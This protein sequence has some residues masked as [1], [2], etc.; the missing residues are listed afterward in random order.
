MMGAAAAGAATGTGCAAVAGMAA[1]WAVGSAR[2][3]ACAV[4]TVGAGPTVMGMVG[5]CT[6]VAATKAQGAGAA[7]LTVLARRCLAGEPVAASGRRDDDAPSVALS[8][9]VVRPSDMAVAR[10]MSAARNRSSSSLCTG[11]VAEEPCQGEGGDKGSVA[12][13]VWPSRSWCGDW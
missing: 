12:Y 7:S 3:P 13:L 11:G 8:C 6:G 2:G 4:M 9:S 10:A 1:A 5:A